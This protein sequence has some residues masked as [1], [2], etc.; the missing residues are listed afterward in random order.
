MNKQQARELITETL[1]EIELNSVEAV[2]LLMGTMA[3]ESHMGEYIRQLGGGPALGVF[4]ME[5]ATYE[6][7]WR[8]TLDYKPKLKDKILKLSVTGEVSELRWNLKLAIAMCRVRYL[9]AKGAIPFGLQAQ[10]EYW[11]KNY[12]GGALGKGTV[13]EY[14]ENYKRFVQ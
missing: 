8:N 12:N 6:S 4:Q 7:L 3:Q 13:E 1:N 9:I 11:K 5:P 2:N 14:I 10:A